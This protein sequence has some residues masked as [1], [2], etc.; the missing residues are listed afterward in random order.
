MVLFVQVSTLVDEVTQ[1]AFLALFKRLRQKI[2]DQVQT[3]QTTVRVARLTNLLVVA[4]F[5]RIGGKASVR[6][7]ELIP[8]FEPAR[9][10]SE[11]ES[12]PPPVPSKSPWC[13]WYK[14]APLRTRSPRSSP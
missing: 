12:G 5:Y 2:K 1:A 8:Q 10:A 7:I 3:T 6:L 11:E 9:T 14:S 13:S 4:D